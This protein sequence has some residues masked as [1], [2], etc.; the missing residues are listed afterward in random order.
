[1]PKVSPCPMPRSHNTI[2][3]KKKKAKK[4]WHI[5]CFFCFPLKVNGMEP[6]NWLENQDEKDMLIQLKLVYCYWVGTFSKEIV[7]KHHSYISSAE[8]TVMKPEETALEFYR[9]TRNG[10][11]KQWYSFSVPNLFSLLICV[12]SP[13]NSFHPCE[14]SSIGFF[15]V[16]Y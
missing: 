9:R 12:K 3:K 1:M 10:E 2:E 16:S 6:I 8:F 14:K 13:I 15:S 11:T 4:V 5:N 7:V